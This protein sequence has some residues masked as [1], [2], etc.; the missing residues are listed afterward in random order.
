MERALRGRGALCVSVVSAKLSC[1]ARFRNRRVSRDPE[2]AR[3]R[4]S[5]LT[6]RVSS[7][8]GR[9]I[10][11]PSLG[12]DNSLTLSFPLSCAGAPSDGCAD[13]QHPS[14]SAGRMTREME[15]TRENGKKK[16]KKEPGRSNSSRTLPRRVC[17][18]VFLRHARLANDGGML[19]KGG[20]MF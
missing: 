10:S 5:V 6:A 1:S 7:E 8:G 15:M 16:K 13:V 17:G 4:A 14:V 9:T 20:R 11:P 19:I 3:A 12:R 18:Y 2:R